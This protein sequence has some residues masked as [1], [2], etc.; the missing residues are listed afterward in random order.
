MKEN[1]IYEDEI[2]LFDLLDKLNKQ[3]KLIIGITAIS[4]ILAIITSLMIPK[5]YKAE[6]FFEVPIIN[7]NNINNV[8]NISE[9][10]E[11]IKS[12]PELKNIKILPIKN[13]PVMGKIEIESKS[14][15]NAKKELETAINIINN[16]ILSKKREEVS[17][18]LNLRQNSINKA[19]LEI[20]SKNQIIYDP[21][22][23]VDLLTEKEQI[24]KWLKNP[25]WILPTS[26]IQLLPDPRRPKPL[27]YT[28]IGFIGGLFLGIFIALLKDAIQNR[29]RENV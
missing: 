4:T 27:I 13:S 26:E 5:V 12:Y 3:K 2:D 29:K 1:E 19:I 11:V 22:K 7:I 24:E 25:N 23:V 14:P 16:D 15:E 18:K 6:V 21:T 20:N 17:Q 8:I 10:Q 9:I 28:A